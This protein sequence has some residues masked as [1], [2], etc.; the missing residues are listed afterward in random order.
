MR[1]CLHSLRRMYARMARGGWEGGC[2]G[3]GLM[4]LLMVFCLCNKMARFF[5]S[6]ISRL[7]LQDIGLGIGHQRPP[8]PL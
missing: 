7:A 2:W 1:P 5:A 6:I 4:A 3:W 8:R